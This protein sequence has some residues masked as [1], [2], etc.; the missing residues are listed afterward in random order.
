[1]NEDRKTGPAEKADEAQGPGLWHVPEARVLEAGVG[2]G[3]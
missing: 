2:A 1:M 3:R